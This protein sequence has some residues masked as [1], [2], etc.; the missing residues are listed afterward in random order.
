MA[1]ASKHPLIGSVI[2]SSTLG[3]K[4]LRKTGDDEPLGA[5]LAEL[6]QAWVDSQSTPVATESLQYAAEEED[7]ETSE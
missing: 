1:P 7:K 2:T 3:S 4:R 6:Q 5:D